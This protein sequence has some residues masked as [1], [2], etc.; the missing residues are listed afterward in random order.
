MG[1]ANNFACYHPSTHR[2][3]PDK[4]TAKRSPLQRFGFRRDH[5]LFQAALTKSF[6]T[7]TRRL[8][9]ILR[10]LIVTKGS[11]PPFWHVAMNV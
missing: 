2:E 5:P 7:A 4:N 6:T 10:L 1:P 3:H 9:R 8:V 11:T